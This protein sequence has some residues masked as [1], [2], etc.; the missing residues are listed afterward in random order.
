MKRVLV[1]VVAACSAS[2]GRASRTRGADGRCDP[3]PRQGDPCG[4]G[5][6][7]CVIDWGRPGGSSAALWCRG[8][9]WVYEE[10]ANLPDDSR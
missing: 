10:E 8:G 3:M 6:S 7:Y 4:A 9:R 5:D 1:V 2:G